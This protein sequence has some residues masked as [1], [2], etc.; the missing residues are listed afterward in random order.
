MEPYI[1][2]IQL[3]A[4]N[5]PPKNWAFCD[6]R[7]LSIA[8]NQA[9]FSLIGT[10]YGGDGITT[11]AL[12]DLRGRTPIG[13][14]QGPGLTYREMGETSGSETV[15]LISTQMPMHNHL[16]MASAQSANQNSPENHFMAVSNGV[17]SNSESPV[18]VNTYGTTASTT[19]NPMSISTS[20]GS[21]PHNN[22]Q[23]YLTMNYCI[24]LYGI[25]PS[26]S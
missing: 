2:Q 8:Q 11:F 6:G 1:G 17:D 22:M 16:L 13:F 10:T 7:L 12:P 3:F 20:G 25:F 15:T 24:A 26:R 14:G 19:A 18:S 23:P 21:Q 9:L 4:F 5:F